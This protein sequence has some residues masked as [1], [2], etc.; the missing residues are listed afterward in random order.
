M[1]EVGS[2][3]AAC[4]M[5]LDSASWLGRFPMLPHVPRFPMGRGPQVYKERLSWPI[6]AARTVCF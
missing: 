2:G 1:T 5:A 4:P 3:A 6:Y